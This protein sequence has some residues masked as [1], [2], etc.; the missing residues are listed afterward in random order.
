MVDCIVES[1][2]EI[3]SGVD[4]YMNDDTIKLTDSELEYHNVIIEQKRAADLI[5]SHW[6]MHL[7]NK[8]KISEN[9]G[10]TDDGEVVIS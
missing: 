2:L 5:F 1:V 9:G 10:I 8:Y 7:K 3:M 6:M 4:T